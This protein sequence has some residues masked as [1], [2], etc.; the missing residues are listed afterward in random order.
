MRKTIILFV[1]ALFLTPATHGGEFKDKLGVGASLGGNKLFCDLHHTNI[2]PAFNLLATYKLHPKI[3]LMGSLGYGA[4]N[5][6]DHC[7]VPPDTITINPNIIPI[8]LKGAYRLPALAKLSPYLHLGVEVFNFLKVDERKRYFDGS[9]L[10]GGGLEYPLTENMGLNLMGDYHF[11][12][13]DNLDGSPN[14]GAKDGYFSGS[15]GLVYYFKRPEG[16]APPVPEEPG[17]IIAKAEEEEISVEELT[18][19]EEKE[20]PAEEDKYLRYAELKSLIDKLKGE[21]E[22]KDEEINRLKLEIAEKESRIRQLKER[23]PLLEEE[24]IREAVQALSPEEYKRRYDQGLESFFSR[25]YRG[26]LRIFEELLSAN[27]THPL[28]GNCQYWIGEC[29]NGL[30]KT[31]QA[32]DAFERVL[33]YRKTPKKAAAL[34]MLG[35]CYRKI[36]DRATAREK[37]S[38]V[39]DLY[40][41]SE[42]ARKARRYL[43]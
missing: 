38:Q 25:D 36:G 8:Q 35:I 32:I 18:Y 16:I 26:A 1:A 2:G 39:I 10:I 33:T 14:R 43:R 28:A 41:N 34:L 27:P 17:K 31:S 11:T 20:A 30:G 6:G 40:P 37:F 7:W 24:R 23:E 21:L 4:F 29:Y 13:G 19:P 15:V 22:K 9:F 5:E 12:T 42:F 3:F